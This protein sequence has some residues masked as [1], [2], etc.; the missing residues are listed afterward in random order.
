MLHHDLNTSSLPL[1]IVFF[2]VFSGSD[3]AKDGW[4]DVLPHIVFLFAYVITIIWA[5]LQVYSATHPVDMLHGCSFIMLSPAHR[6]LQRVPALCLLV[7]RFQVSLH[8]LGHVAAGHFCEQF[9]APMASAA[10]CRSL[11][12][13]CSR[14]RWASPSCGASTR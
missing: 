3:Q 12:A 1:Q 8:L 7:F 5:V 2:H 4:Q 10:Q 14:D 6:Q 13:S 9:V 11:L